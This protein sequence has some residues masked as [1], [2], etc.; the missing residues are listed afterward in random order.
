MTITS[1]QF[2]RSFR[3]GAA[4][5]SSTLIAAALLGNS[6][7]VQASLAIQATFDSTITG[8]ANAAAIEGVIN[9]AV[10]AYQSYFS[11]PVTVNINFQE[12]S[13]GLGQSNTWLA[14]PYSYSSYRAVLAG[15]ATTS[16]DATAYN[17]LPATNPI[18]G[19]STGGIT[20]SS[21]N[22]KALTGGGITT[23]DGFDG[24]V[25]LNTHITNV[26]SPGTSGQY[27]LLATVEH[28]I[29]EVLGLGS[30]LGK[31][32]LRPQDLFRFTQAGARTYTT[33]GDDAYFSINGGTA[34]LARFNQSSGGDYG[35]WWS[36]G[37]HTPQVQDAFA[38][39]GANPLLG[40]SELTALD[41][42][43]YNRVSATPVPIPGAG[44]LFFSAT[45]GLLGFNRRTAG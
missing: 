8:D 11:N 32:D 28:E 39:P 43:G 10:Q 26:G 30:G 40:N 33:S 38:T 17:A 19:N 23:P 45:A 37:G 29:D 25:S 9:T 2:N 7:A 41:V 36:T 16:D 22:Y 14:G 3:G 15:T 5:L 12:M 1:F 6:A 18:P 44:W 35:D 34:L 20:I 31:S 21:A 27:S 24:T 42:I 4:V 13:S